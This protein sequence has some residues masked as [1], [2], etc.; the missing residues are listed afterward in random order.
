MFPMAFVT[1][2]PLTSGRTGPP[3]LKLPL[4]YTGQGKIL[5]S[6]HLL[7][8]HNCLPCTLTVSSPGSNIP[9]GLDVGISVLIRSVDSAY[10]F[11]EVARCVA[12]KMSTKES[13][14][15][16]DTTPTVLKTS[17]YQ[18]GDVVTIKN[19]ALY[20]RHFPDIQLRIVRFRTPYQF[21]F[22]KSAWMHNL[23]QGRLVSVPATMLPQ[24][25][26]KMYY[27]QLIYTTNG[28]RISEVGQHNCLSA[29][30]SSDKW[31]DLRKKEAE[32]DEERGFFTAFFSMA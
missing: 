21:L 29:G 28:S 5:P 22:S 2:R 16:Y 8:G 7:F 14:C 24:L 13:Y 32:E 3:Q 25:T 4:T 30:A 6:G 12:N 10:Q 17:W 19:I 31:K 1:S 18:T 27:L 23:N 9:C 15:V 20:S 11:L 26:H